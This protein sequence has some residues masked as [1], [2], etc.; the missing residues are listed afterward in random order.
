MQLLE[1]FHA[2]DAEDVLTRPSHGEEGGAC[3]H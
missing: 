2:H 1:H 3:Q